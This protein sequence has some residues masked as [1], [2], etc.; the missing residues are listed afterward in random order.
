MFL[1]ELAALPSALFYEQEEESIFPSNILWQ[2]FF[3]IFFHS[4]VDGRPRF[5]WRQIVSTVL[6]CN[7]MTASNM[8]FLVCTGP[9]KMK[10]K[11]T[12]QTRDG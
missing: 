5:C 8:T 12:K 3:R 6:N 9:R 4:D 11:Q 1:R 2:D 10:Q 7:L